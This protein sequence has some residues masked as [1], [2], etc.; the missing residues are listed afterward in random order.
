[1]YVPKSKSATYTIIFYYMLIWLFQDIIK[2]SSWVLIYEFWDSGA[3]S[4]QNMESYI[5]LVFWAPLIL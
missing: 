4:T 1:M 2:L 3:F 5:L